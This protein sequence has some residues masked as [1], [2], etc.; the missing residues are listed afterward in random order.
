MVTLRWAVIPRAIQITVSTGIIMIRPNL[1]PVW[2]VVLIL[3]VILTPILLK[4]VAESVN[5]WTSVMFLFRPVVITVL[6]ILAR[7]SPIAILMII[8]MN[9]GAMIRMARITVNT[10][11]MMM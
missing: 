8:I 6:L 1:V 4:L 2:T 3:L 9:Q 10:E 11:I 7:E 5:M